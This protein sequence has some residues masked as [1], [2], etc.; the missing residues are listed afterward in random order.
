[1][2]FNLEFIESMTRFCVNIFIYV[3]Q[4]VVR[5][6]V[7]ACDGSKYNVSK[8]IDAEFFVP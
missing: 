8:E 7:L 4:G 1:M 2:Y 3:L 5:G 6:V